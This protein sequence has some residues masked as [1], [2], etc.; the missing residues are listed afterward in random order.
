MP[1]YQKTFLKQVILR[2]D[3][4]RLVALQVE[5]PP[6]FTEDMKPRYPEVTAN[7]IQ[8]FSVMMTPPGMNF[9]QQSAV[10]WIRVH[11]AKDTARSVTLAPDFLAIEYGG[12]AYQHFDELAEQASFVLASFRKHFGM[13][14]F[15]RIGL[16]YVNEITFPEGG[17]LEWD[18]LINPKLVTSVKAGLLKDSRMA[19]SF[20]Q[21]IAL[22]DD[23]S[24]LL[25]YGIFNPEFPNPVA[26]RQFVIDLDCY[27]SG[28]VESIEA[29]RR[30]KDVNTAAEEVFENSIEDGLRKV[31][32]IVK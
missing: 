31:M 30:I 7:Q 23:I 10:G 15:T 20:H 3:Y 17:P 25:S 32:G 4:A 29:E 28:V 2:L 11:K 26:R 9:G 27:V 1:H 19:R 14:Q 16:R 5:Q 6:P 21:L 24:V 18:G 22:R 12:E 13:V 8:H